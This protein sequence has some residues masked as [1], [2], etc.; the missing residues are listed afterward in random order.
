[1]TDK[2]GDRNPSLL[3]QVVT[4]VRDSVFT[5]PLEVFKEEALRALKP[6]ISFDAALWATGEADSRVIY[7]VALVD[8]AAE[9]LLEYSA[10]WQDQDFVRAA[11]TAT[12][13]RAFRNEDVLP[14]GDHQRTDIYQR[15]CRP[16][17][18]EQAL[19]I[20]FVDEVTRVGEMIFLFRASPDAFY[21]EDDC[22]AA[23]R[24]FP[25][26]VGAWRHRQLLHAY[27][28]HRQPP[29]KLAVE[30][31]AHAVIDGAGRIHAAEAGFGLHLRR[32]FPA[33]NGP[34]L[35]GAVLSRLPGPEDVVDIGDLRLTLHPSGD[36]P[37]LAVRPRGRALPLT[38]AEMRVCRS[39][40]DGRSARAIADELGLSQRTVR[41]HLAAAYAKLEVHTR[42]Q[43]IERLRA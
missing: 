31:V 39:Y 42:L 20:A 25:H 10:H 9:S 15:Y 36:R 34:L 24:V 40:A 23:E 14:P 19:G 4:D 16:A 3:D 13:G 5:T 21:S 7:G 43:L 33:W 32:Q 1:M 30:G 28:H 6:L 17:G 8:F 41:N 2:S 12:P 35:P 37:V 29:E 22:R 26:Y 38:P 18:L 11:A 27:E